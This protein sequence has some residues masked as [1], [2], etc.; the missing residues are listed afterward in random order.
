MKKKTQKILSSDKK[1]SRL[2]IDSALL[3]AA[4]MLSMIEGIIP[5]AVI[6]LPG[7]KLGLANIAITVAAYRYSLKDAAIISFARI[8]IVFLLFGG[9]TTVI[10][11]VFG[12]ILSL[13]TL[14]LMKTKPLSEKFSFIGISVSSAAAHNIGQ[15]TAASL[16]VSPASLSYAPALIFAAIICGGLNGIVLSALPNVIFKTTYPR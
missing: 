5:L 15:L 1:I 9:V 11:S 14:A 13:L 6:P 8:L 7:F 10:F 12:S 2:S 3:G 4:L 16:V